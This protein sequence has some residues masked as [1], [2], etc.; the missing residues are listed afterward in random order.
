MGPPGVGKTTI[1]K[2]MGNIYLRLGFLENDNFITAM[3]TMILNKC[4]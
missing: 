2:I 3:T 1:A 4:S